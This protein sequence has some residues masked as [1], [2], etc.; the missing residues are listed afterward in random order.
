MASQI[1][2]AS[3]LA[4]LLLGIALAAAGVTSW[5][6]PGGS[7]SVDAD[8]RLLSAPTGELQVSPMGLFLSAPS[9]APGDEAVRGELLVRNQTGSALDVRLRA[10]PSSPD[11]DELLVVRMDIGKDRIF[12]G[13]LGGLRTWTERSFQL[14]SDE[15]RVLRAEAWFPRRVTSGYEGRIADVTIEMGVEVFRG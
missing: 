4:G 6:V 13:T 2:W 5:R 15:R 14:A 9:L 1:E 11:L 10:L 3:R 12:E 8:V 7:G